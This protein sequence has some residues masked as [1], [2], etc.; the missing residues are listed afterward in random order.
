MAVKTLYTFN[1]VLIQPARSSIEP[2]EALVSSVAARGISLKV[3]I[4]SAAMDRV[5]DE[6]LAIALA[7]AG[8]LGVLHR[9]CTKEQEVAMVEKVKAAGMPVAAACGPFD[10]ERARALSQAGADAIVIDC[11]HGHNLKVLKSAAAIKKTLVAQKSGTKLIIGNIATAEAARDIIRIVNPDAIKVGVGPGSICTTRIVSGV[12][13][14][15]L[16]AVQDVVFAARRTK[17]PVIADGGMRFSGDVAKALAAGASAVMLGNMLAGTLESPGERIEKDGITYKSYRGMGSMAVL[18]ERQSS[19]RYLQKNLY[20]V[21]E[22]VEGLVKVTG[23]VEET[24][25]EILSGVKIA[26]GYVGAKDIPTFQR[27]AKFVFVTQA[28]LSES[29]PHSLASLDKEK[30]NFSK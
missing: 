15:Q 12:G 14:P 21:A 9:N 24:V 22:G 11:A 17:T 30:W 19:D 28:S 10:A 6:N 25:G 18:K 26:M 20:P 4:L 8:G 1:D 13:V 16:S 23:S 29:T 3:P 2:S 5:T 7:K 27:R